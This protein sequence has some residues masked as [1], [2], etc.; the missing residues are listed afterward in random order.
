MSTAPMSLNMPV[1]ACPQRLLLFGGI[2]SNYFSHTTPKK[3]T[4]INFQ[5]FFEAHVCFFMPAI[6]RPQGRVWSEA[7]KPLASKQPLK[8]KYER[9]EKSRATDQVCLCRQWARM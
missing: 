7:E 2:L 5:I 3:S 6:A 9:L 4:Q 1:T 8:R